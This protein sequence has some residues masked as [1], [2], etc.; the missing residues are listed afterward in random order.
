MDKSVSGVGPSILQSPPTAFALT[1]AFQL[2]LPQHQ[3]GNILP[4][5]HAMKK[6]YIKTN[7]YSDG[8]Q[9][10]PHIISGS[11]MQKYILKDYYHLRL[12]GYHWWH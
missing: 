7:H 10:S 6:K 11:E 1:N 5:C 9:L 3:A 12:L 4:Q 8:P 2:V